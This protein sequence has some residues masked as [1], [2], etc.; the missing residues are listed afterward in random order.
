MDEI[1]CSEEDLGPGDI[2]VLTKP[3]RIFLISGE[4]T[5]L[6]HTLRAGALC[7]VLC[8]PEREHGN[9]KMSILTHNGV[10]TIFYAEF[11]RPFFI[12]K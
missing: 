5:I 2:I 1:V 3:K 4:S 7:L 8:T 9:E 12:I 6:F 10:H 11:D